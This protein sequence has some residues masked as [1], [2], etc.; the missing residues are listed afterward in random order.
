MFLEGIEF[1]T[2]LFILY[3]DAPSG[4]NFSY[5]APFL[6]KTYHQGRPSSLF[7]L[8]FIEEHKHVHE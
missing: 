8:K 6:S 2:S 4:S 3:Y 7:F 5:V 1:E